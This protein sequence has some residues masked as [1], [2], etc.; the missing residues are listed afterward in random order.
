MTSS[1]TDRLIGGHRGHGANYWDRDPSTFQYALRENTVT[2]FVASIAAGASFVEFDVQVTRDGV[3]IVWHDNYV[4]TGT[5]AAPRS[6]LVAEL[7]SAEFRRLLQARGASLLSDP[8]EQAQEM[9]GL[10]PDQVHTPGGTPA[11]L[12]SAGALLRA[13]RN[14]SPAEPND[15]SLRPWECAEGDTLLPCLEDLFE[16][17]PPG[18]AFDL[19][20]KLATEN[21]VARTPDVEIDRLLC[22][23]LDVVDAAAARSLAAGA[24]PREVLFSSF[25]PDLC[26]ELR[27]RRPL[28]PVMFLSGGGAY[29]HVDARRIGLD[30][31]LDWAESAHLDGVI[32]HSGRLRQQPEFVGKVADRGLRLLSYGLEN[33]ETEWVERQFDLGV[34]GVIVDDVTGVVKGL[35]DRRLG[36]GESLQHKEGEAGGMPTLA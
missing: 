22:P 9:R 28:A 29:E 16:A 8:Q 36:E 3:P 21:D 32:V 11:P 13:L 17:L 24:Q 5:S 26:A 1:S 34:H 33:S 19:E 23:I 14:D 31:A 10:G 2:S 35:T 12:G 20:V 4:I 25:D 6:R 7:T 30:A 27:R 15:P 18:V